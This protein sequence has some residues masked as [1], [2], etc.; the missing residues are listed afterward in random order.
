MLELPRAKNAH[1]T[2]TGEVLDAISAQSALESADVY[3]GGNG[4][5]ADLDRGQIGQRHAT[6]SALLVHRAKTERHA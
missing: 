6:T 3:Q 5:L 1:D 4:E 2:F